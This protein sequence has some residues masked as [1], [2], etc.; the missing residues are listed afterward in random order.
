MC[1]L[2]EYEKGDLAKGRKTMMNMERGCEVM[3][4][5]LCKPAQYLCMKLGQ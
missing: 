2:D 4:Q 5:S 3:I 1:L